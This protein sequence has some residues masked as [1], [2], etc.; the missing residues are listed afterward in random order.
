[1]NN[2]LVKIKKRCKKQTKIYFL[3]QFINFMVSIEIRLDS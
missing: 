2:L 1:M 3:E